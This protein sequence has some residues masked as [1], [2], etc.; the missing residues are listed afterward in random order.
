MGQQVH[1]QRIGRYAVLGVLGRGAMGVVYR[2][3]DPR[4][5]RVVALKT[6]VL[7]QGV[8]AT[9]AH[10]LKA[11]FLNEA[12]AAGRLSHP[13]IVTVHDADEDPETGIAYLAME[14][15]EGREL[16]DLLA[17]GLSPQQLLAILAQVADALQ[18]AHERGI[19]HRDVKPA[20]ILVSADGRAKLADF[21]IARLEASTLTQDGQLL[22]SPAYMAPEQVQARPISPATDVYALAVIL[23]EGLTGRKPFQGP[24]LI[25]TTHA[26]VATP[27]PRASTIRPGLSPALDAVLGRGL[28]KAP[29]QRQRTPR[30]LVDDVEHTLSG[31]PRE[32]V[33]DVEH[34]PSGTPVDARL[35]PGRRVPGAGPAGASVGAVL[36]W[37]RGHRPAAV[38]GAVAG[39]AAVLLVGWLA[40]TAGDGA[41]PNPAGTSA[42]AADNWSWAGGEPSLGTTGPTAEVA[43]ASR[44][45]AESGAASIGDPADDWSW[46]EETPTVEGEALDEGA[47]A[48]LPAPPSPTPAPTAPPPTAPPPTAPAGAPA[49]R[50]ATGAPPAPS[51]EAAPAEPAPAP[52]GATGR[53]E[54]HLYTFQGGVLTVLLGEQVV[55]RGDVAQ[56]RK[57]GFKLKNPKRHFQIPLDVPA[58]RHVITFVYDP[59]GSEPPLTKRSVQELAPGGTIR[60]TVDIGTLGR[61]MDLRVP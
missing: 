32:L 16:K 37:A 55:H 35:S 10:Q 46:A 28:A 47:P 23:F 49:S 30:E 44:P 42:A 58:G 54:V 59:S 9:T 51:P 50:R 25:A 21:G 5:D 41:P 60:V 22:G 29:D 34:A 27:A 8:D 12:R 61:D 57:R 13:A 20:N 6:L 43:A 36:E 2:A 26:I 4:I 7:P 38:G 40:W 24:G 1:P 11:R 17:E 48:A 15:I 19:V 33:D 14:Y 52:A 31:T 39:V 18:H 45:G 53:L 56:E 3:R